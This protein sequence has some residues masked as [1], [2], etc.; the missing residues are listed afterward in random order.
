A[1]IAQEQRFASVTDENH[2]IV[3]NCELVHVS[4]LKQRARIAA[5]LSGMHYQ[6]PICGFDA[7]QLG[8][9]RRD[10]AIPPKPRPNV[11]RKAFHAA[12][13]RVCVRSS[14]GTRCAC[15]ARFSSAPWWPGD[16]L[17]R[18]ARNADK[19]ISTKGIGGGDTAVVRK[20][21]GLSEQRF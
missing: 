8:G 6:R 14:P 3:G 10:S 17:R 9:R 19:A 1:V 5:G 11:L 13:S 15:R 18:G 20:S 16:V 21:Q 2:G 4:L 12:S 7:D